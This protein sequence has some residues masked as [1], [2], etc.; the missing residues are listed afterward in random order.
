MARRKKRKSPFSGVLIVFIILSLIVLLVGYKFYLG[1]F[2]PNINPAYIQ[3]HDVIEIKSG[4]TYDQV[5]D[6][7]ERDSVL[8]DLRS[9][10]LVAKKM[11]YANHIYA[12][13][14][15][16]TKDMNNYDLIKMLRAGNNTPF[17]LTIDKYR[18][19]YELAGGVGAQLE[20]DSAE[21]VDF[22]LEKDF[23]NEHNLNSENALSYFIPNSYEFYWNT[24]IENFFNRMQKEADKFWNEERIEKAKAIRFSKAEVYT[25]ASIVQEEAVYESELER[26]AGVY[27]N[28]M[29]KKM[30]LQAD[31]TIK[32]LIKDRKD[33]KL[34]LNDYK[35]TS[36]YNTY[37]NSGLTPG[38]IIMARMSAMDA[39]L[40]A[41]RHEFLY[42]CAKADGSGFHEFSTNLRQ[43]TNYR[44]LYLRSKKK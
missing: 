9:F 23:L 24:S 15:P 44:N 39:V 11:N 34:Y 27:L 2:A 37:E 38:P 4:M 17:M 14:Y 35:I 29:R 32:F 20:I 28:R 12:R 33:Q 5:L 26:I 36:S 19:I 18:T 43:H 8:L 13:R 22:I 31:P 21:I 16:V 25:M 10:K 42:F 3:K 7:F 40:N 30:R 41:E 1:I 6:Q